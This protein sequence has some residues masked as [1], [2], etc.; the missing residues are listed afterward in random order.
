MLSKFGSPWSTTV[1]Y[2]GG[3]PRWSTTV[4]YHGGVPRW[5]TTV[6]YH[7]GVPRWSTTRAQVSRVLTRKEENS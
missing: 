5:S 3:V 1:E 4:E 7:G 2:H 6:E